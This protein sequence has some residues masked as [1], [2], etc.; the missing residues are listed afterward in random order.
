[1]RSRFLIAAAL[2]AGCINGVDDGGAPKMCDDTSDCDAESGE[3]C[4][5]GVC[6]GDPPDGVTFAP[7]LVRPDARADL[8]VAVI[9]ALS[10]ADDGTI[11]GLDFPA[12]VT[13]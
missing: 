10:I 2:L 11:V 13:V 6:W 4:D 7:V 9:P 1:M 12:A 8:R 3:V 5:E